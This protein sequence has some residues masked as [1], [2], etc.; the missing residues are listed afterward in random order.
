MALIAL[1]AS[2]IA[3]LS[4]FSAYRYKRLANRA[5]DVLE[6]ARGSMAEIRKDMS[7]HPIKMLNAHLDGFSILY[8][9]LRRYTEKNGGSAIITTNQ[10]DYVMLRAE[11]KHAIQHQKTAKKIEEITKPIEMPQDPF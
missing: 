7:K 2:I 4:L 10:I 9:E 5:A 1:I 6:W 8:K 3:L 11:Q